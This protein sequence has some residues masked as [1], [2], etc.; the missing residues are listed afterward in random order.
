MAYTGTLDQTT[1]TITLYYPSLGL[2]Y[3]QSS[4][5]QQWSIP[6]TSGTGYT[7]YTRNVNSGLGYGDWVVQQYSGP[8]VVTSTTTL[9]GTPPSE[10]V[11]FSTDNTNPFITGNGSNVT[12]TNNLTLAQSM[13]LAEATG[14]PVF[15]DQST[16][17]T[18]GNCYT[19]TLDLSAASGSDQTITLTLKGGANNMVV[20]G[21]TK[22]F[23]KFNGGTATIIVPAGQSSLE[24]T[25][26]DGNNVSTADLLTLTATI[27]GPNGTTSNNLAITFTDPNPGLGVAP[28]PT[29]VGGTGVNGYIE[30]SSVMVNGVNVPTEIWSGDG[31]STIIGGSSS[32]SGGIYAGEI[33]TGAAQNATGKGSNQI[34]VNKQVDLATALAQQAASP[35]TGDPGYEIW[36]NDG[37]NTI[38]GGYGDDS[39]YA[40]QGDNTIVFG[41]GKNYLVSGVKLSYDKLGTVK[42]AQGNTSFSPYFSLPGNT[43]DANGN[44]VLDIA[45][46]SSDSLGTQVNGAPVGLGNDTIYGGS[47]DSQYLLTNGNNWLDA[48]GGDDIIQSGTGNNTIYGGDGNDSIWGAGG[49]DYIDL[50]GGSDQVVLNG[51]NNTLYGGTG[52][53]YIASG[54]NNAS[55]WANSDTSSTNYIESGS[56][57]DTIFGSGG[58]DTLISNSQ[59]GTGNATTATATAIYAGN[60]NEY[61]EGG[62]GNDTIFGGTGINT[63][64]AG[65]GNNNIQLST[66]ASENSS[67]YGGSG[68]YTIVGGAGTNFIGMGN[69]NTVVQL[70]S[71]AGETSTVYGGGGNDSISAANDFE[72]RMVA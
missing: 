8:G 43:F 69:G 51:G 7:I 24:L 27:P 41:N 52:N 23:I 5:L 20:D 58:T 21:N 56:G 66:N 18:N 37:N 46:G 59:S 30:G 50:E 68:N 53:S 70:S 29:L 15:A 2:R 44:V 14:K 40:G 42:N 63:I 19:C 36:V 38:V 55:N 65:A 9:T 62:A 49:N 11:T 61:I 13:A 4:Y 35:T 71:T 16:S 12:A 22:E 47:G 31:N 60:G 17:V 33:V 54:D 28:G 57:N 67:V 72:W 25:I 64:Y 32:F 6:D 26:I 3:I 1:G 39:I 10:L 34:Y 45:Y 48:G